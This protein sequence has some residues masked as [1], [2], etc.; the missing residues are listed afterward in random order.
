[1]RKVQLAVEYPIEEPGLPMPHLVA[2][3]VSAF[4]VEAER[5]GLLL[6]SSPIPDVKHTRRVVAVRADV[7]ERPARR[8]AQ[9]P[10]PPAFQ[11][12][13]CGQPIFSTGQEEDRK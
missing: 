7:V 6:V 11:C 1:M 12:P 8:A 10:T 13:Q 5:Q 3:A 9:E 4:V 2:S